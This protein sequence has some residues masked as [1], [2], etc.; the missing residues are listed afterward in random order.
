MA[1]ELTFVT[2]CDEV[3]RA[4]KATAGSKA[5]LVKSVVNQ[6]YLS[7]VMVCDELFPLFWLR[8]FDD[9]QRAVAPA[10]ITGITAASPAVVSATNSLVNGDIVSI[11]NVVGMTEVN[12]RF[13][14][15][16]NRAAGS[17][18][19]ENLDATD[20]D[21]SGYTAWSSGGT[22]HHRGFTIAETSPIHR[23]LT[24]RWPDEG[25]SGKVT[26]IDINELESTYSLTD[27][28]TGQP[29]RF[30]LRKGF[31]STGGAL[32]ETNQLLWFPG[33]DQAYTP[34]RYWYVNDVARLSADTDIPILPPQF[35][36]VIIA[37]AITRLIESH[38]QIENAV[39]W[40]G[41][42]RNQIRGLRAYNRQFYQNT[43][44]EDR[45]K[46]YLL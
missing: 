46:P 37:G 9:T 26:P 39:V 10:T 15:V 7:E 21:S 40:P 23:I 17:I 24:A 14:L 6:V 35:H 29:E 38:F 4:V 27:D 31:I 44:I 19:L 20:I 34:F 3:E 42:Y 18:E 36:D 32:T 5:A 28:G 11:H 13:F 41:I 16:S 2:I 22:V 30:M 25:E 45:P 33:A 8:D 1:N 43:D 12:D